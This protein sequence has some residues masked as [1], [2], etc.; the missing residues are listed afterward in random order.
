MA[1][2]FIS[3]A[4]EDRERAKEL[5][6]ALAERGWSVWWDREMLAGQSFADVI[7]SELA[8]VKA[9]IVLW[10]KHSVKSQWARNEAR[11]G[12]ARNVLVPVLIDDSR[13]P[14]EFR[15]LHTAS[16]ADWDAGTTTQELEDVMSS[17]NALVSSTGGTRVV[18]PPRVEVTDR[19]RFKRSAS[20]AIA[21]IVV[22]L[23]VIAI[24][25][26]RD[27]WSGKTDTTDTTITTTTSG[28]VA[29][30]TV[31]TTTDT[32]MVTTDTTTTTTEPPPATDTTETTVT[33]T[34][35]TDTAPPPQRL[36]YGAKAV[37][38]LVVAGQPRC[39]AFLISDEIAVTASFCVK[40]APPPIVMRLGLTSETANTRDYQVESVVVQ[41]DDKKFAVLKIRLRP[42][43]VFT[44]IRWRTRTARVGETATLLH[45]DQGQPLSVTPCQVTAVRPEE[46][47]YRCATRSGASGAPLL[48][49]DNS[50]LGFHSGSVLRTD[51][52]L[53]RGVATSVFFDSIRRWWV[54]RGG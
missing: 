23:I 46:V 32:V 9:V 40:D 31:M 7:E 52:L 51:P 47:H 28:S 43:R 15:H 30:D 37:G 5:A 10:S 11:E 44:P 21:A 8:T 26:N 13:M 24:V 22:G 27:R 4:R 25:M 34:P 1:D 33:Q 12:A 29:T 41:D 2:I 19:S 14:L 49:S 16:L 53:K 45:H 6:E 35:P 54:P 42:G 18:S 36:P 39:T 3:Y 20:I 38:V 48:G 17:V 50:L